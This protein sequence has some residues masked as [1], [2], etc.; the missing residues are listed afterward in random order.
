M[1]LNTSIIIVCR[2][3]KFWNLTSHQRASS[4]SVSCDCFVVKNQINFWS[5]I[6]IIPLQFVNENI[7]FFPLKKCCRKI[8]VTWPIIFWLGHVC[9]LQFYVPG[10]RFLFIYIF[11]HTSNFYMYWSLCHTPNTVDMLYLG[12]VF[13]L[14]AFLAKKWP[15]LN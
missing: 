9:C 3:W 6:W 12:C 8:E 14:P 10:H 7:P 1:Y 11:S 13:Y 4:V 2:E 5:V 15:P